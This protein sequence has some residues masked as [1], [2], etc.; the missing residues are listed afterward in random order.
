MKKENQFFK[1][2]LRIA[3]GIILSASFLATTA[4]ALAATN[5][6]DNTAGGDFNVS[7]NWTNSVVPGEGDLAVF[8]MEVATA[9]TVRVDVANYDLGTLQLVND[10]VV[11]DL[12]GQTMNLTD[13][14]TGDVYQ[15]EG[16]IY[17]SFT[18]R[19]PL[20]VARGNPD[21]L[22]HHDANMVII[23][24][25]TLNTLGLILAGTSDSIGTLIV[26]DGTTLNVNNTE[27]AHALI[28]P[29]GDGTFQILEGSTVSFAE[30][31][32]DGSISSE[33]DLLVEGAGSKLESKESR[34]FYRGQGTALIQDGALFNGGILRMGFRGNSS[35]TFNNATGVF[36]QAFYSGL[37]TSSGLFDI[38]NGS[39]VTVTEDMQIGQPVF[40][41]E[42]NPNIDL[43][44]RGQNAESVASRMVCEGSIYLG[45]SDVLDRL[46]K[47]AR[48]SATDGGAAAFNKC[49]HFWSKGSMEV[50]DGTVAASK[51]DARAGAV[52][53]LTLHTGAFDPLV[54][55]TNNVSDANF[56]GDVILDTTGDGVTLNLNAETGFSVN[57]G[58]RFVLIRY[59]GDLTGTFK[60]LPE[61]E[62]MIFDD[63]ECRISY[64]SGSNSSII[65]RGPVAGTLMIIK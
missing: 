48:L 16:N 41:N 39:Q 55:V 60:D 53:D 5:A 2:L 19:T 28:A 31:F 26:C 32:I 15:H 17:D 7:G 24:G 11:L 59:E 23:G 38:S 25:G 50:D 29:R 4:T 45:G 44:V 3:F 40:S 37:G 42:G 54:N 65:L 35:L 64:G 18:Q 36:S 8:D 13:P 63:T 30:G 52:I 46:V 58:D 34:L 1:G 57:G 6:W 22:E 51:I 9:Y 14:V 49:I 20:M 27:R 47:K 62:T 10:K 33:L 43:K 56:N 12:D 61:G 21:P